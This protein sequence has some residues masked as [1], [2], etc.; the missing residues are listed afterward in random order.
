MRFPVP[1]VCAAVSALAFLG[2]FAL[3]N[4][5]STVSYGE[6]GEEAASGPLG[7]DTADVD[8]PFVIECDSVLHG[9][10]RSWN[11]DVRSLD[12][13]LP[14]HSGYSI[15]SD[16]MPSSAGPE[17]VNHCGQIRTGTAGA[18]A[19]LAVPAAVAG[20][21]AVALRRPGRLPEPP[22]PG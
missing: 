12:D 16:S 15:E 7:T 3:L 1:L 22:A 6:P 21:A 19:L 10:A 18:A 9:W 11:D 20:A 2:M 14:P 4:S 8:E 5:E 13:A 17:V